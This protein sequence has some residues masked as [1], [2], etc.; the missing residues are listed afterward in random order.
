ML[1]N[2]MGVGRVD[3]AV[4]QAGTIVNNETSIE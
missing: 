3:D 2:A 1:Y 4:L